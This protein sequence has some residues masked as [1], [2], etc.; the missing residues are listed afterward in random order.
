MDDV[1]L[2]GALL[3]PE[4]L[5]SSSPKRVQLEMKAPPWHCSDPGAAAVASAVVI[6]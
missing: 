4:A 2:S 6:V 1:S 3:F 5:F